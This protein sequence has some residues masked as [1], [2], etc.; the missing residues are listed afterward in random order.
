[1]LPAPNVKAMRRDVAT[2]GANTFEEMYRSQNWRFS[3]WRQDGGREPSDGTFAENRTNWMDHPFPRTGKI[4]LRGSPFP[5]WTRI[6]FLNTH[7]NEIMTLR[8]R[9]RLR[10]AKAWFLPKG[11]FEY[12]K[13]LGHGGMGLT[14]HFKWQSYELGVPDRDIVLKI[15]L[16]GWD[17][18]DLRFEE[19]NMKYVARAA[20][21]IQA[22]DPE[23]IDLEPKA[24]FEYDE[25]D[26]LD[27]SG[28]ETSSDNDEEEIQPKDG[29]IRDGRRWIRATRR[30][31]WENKRLDLD[32]KYQ[33]HMDRVQRQHDLIKL[34]R[35]VQRR[36]KKS[37]SDSNADSDYESMR[38]F[39]LLHKDYLL[40]EFMENGDLAHF[41]YKL[42]ELNE[43][44]PNRVLWSFWLCL[45]KACIAM[46]YP[47]EK[48][49]PRRDEQPKEGNTEED[50]EEE[51]KA[52]KDSIGKRIG[53]DLFEV[54]PTAVGRTRGAR[55][56]HFDL[57]PKN[58]FVG[59]FD[60]TA[61]DGEHSI[62]PR[63]KL[64]DFGCA[65]RIKPNKGNEYY[66]ERR[67]M[68]K[69]CYYAPEQFGLEWEHITPSGPRGW[70]LS[71]Q[72]VAGNYGSP[73]NVYGI[74]LTAWQL[75]TKLWPPAPIQRE[76]RAPEATGDELTYCTLL[77]DRNSEY[78]HVDIELRTAISQC[79]RHYPNRRPTLMNLHRQA[80]RGARKTF[81]NESDAQIKAWIHKMFY[82]ANPGAGNPGDSGDSGDSDDSD[83]S[84]GS[85]G[86]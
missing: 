8:T 33:E 49:H 22:I 84:D 69:R 74:A 70:E 23:D 66:L 13:P 57:D 65:K 9:R 76:T 40:L 72:L 48:F 4:K 14:I 51:E 38:Q 24:P 16:S 55:V 41:I 60:K 71:E 32:L 36:L 11:D 86:S 63:L 12:I 46:E 3:R 6:P 80:T 62:I 30:W 10:Q 52:G 68:A 77:L 15:G 73:M 61:T 43:V 37:D 35:D 18:E 31:K 5:G 21:C 54:V 2:R 19:K 82:Q 45:V 26:E 47:V 1:M 85:D 58:I 29:W 34:R 25:L 20:H 39:D 79:M 56:V 83:G 78:S 53:R 17:D 59:G 28:G 7:S 27:S 64:A 44:V 50:L 81:P 75:I 42:N 67:R